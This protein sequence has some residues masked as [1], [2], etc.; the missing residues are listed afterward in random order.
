VGIADDRLAR[1][2]A[3]GPEGPPRLPH[4]AAKGDGGWVPCRRARLELAMGHSLSSVDVVGAL[5]DILRRL[6]I[7]PLRLR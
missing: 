7:V 4:S 3:T 6:P 1:A 2:A 5:D